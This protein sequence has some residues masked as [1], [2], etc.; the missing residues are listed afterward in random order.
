[1]IKKSELKAIRSFFSDTY[2]H[3][4]RLTDDAIGMIAAT[5]AFKALDDDDDGAEKQAAM[6]KTAED[7]YKDIAVSDP[8]ISGLVAKMDPAFNAELD[9]C[10]EATIKGKSTSLDMYGQ[11]KRI[12]TKE[13]FDGTPMPGWTEDDCKNTNFKP[14]IVE[15]KAVSGGKIRVVFTDDL[16]QAMPKGKAFQQDMDDAT[17]ELKTSGAVKRFAGKGKQFLRDTF[18]YAKLQR[19]TMRKMVRAAIGLHHQISAIEGMPKVRIQW[20]PGASDRCPVIPKNF[21][22]KETFKVTRSGKPFWITALDGT[23]EVPNSGK[24]FSVSQILAFDVRKALAMPDGGTMADLVESAKP[25]PETPEQK[26]EKMS[27]EEQDTLIVSIYS[28]LS[29][30]EERAGWT[31]RMAEKDNET[32]RDAYCGL[33]LILKP[34][35][36]KNAKWYGERI[37][38]DEAQIKEAVG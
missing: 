8:G 6:F 13:Q 35:F 5:P 12:W 37:G 4:L 3:E 24:E 18:N 30:T 32:A 16:V 20:I 34:F 28:K 33:Y 9:A 21:G 19:D 38:L 1:M 2:G 10:I 23:A 11:L 15:K 14:D 36:R 17:A 26:G 25:E 31:K 29:N 27:P 7:A 22:G